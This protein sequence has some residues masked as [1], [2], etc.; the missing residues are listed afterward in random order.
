M[1][2]NNTATMKTRDRYVYGSLARI[3]DLETKPFDVRPLQR[4]NWATGDYIVGRYLGSRCS[5]EKHVVELTTGRI[6]PLLAGD[7]LVGSLAVRKA[8]FETVGDWHLI[9]ADNMM[10]DIC[11]SGM[12]GL[13]TSRS[14]MKQS[15]PA[16]LYQGH[17]VRNGRKVCMKDF[18]PRVTPT[19]PPECPTI[20][21]VGTS[22][23]TGKTNTAKV[24]IR[25]LKEIGFRRVV[26]TKLTG[27][28]YLHD[29]LVMEEGMADVV[30]DFVDAGMPST[31]MPP[32]EYR[33][34]LPTLFGILSSQSP[35]C[36]VAEIGAS[37]CEPYNGR[38]VL[39]EMSPQFVVLCASDAYAV[40]GLQQELAGLQAFHP[41][42]VCGIAADTSA[43]IDL[44]KQLSGLP[45][46]SLTDE[47]SVD[48]LR[49]MLTQALFV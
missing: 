44:V 14:F 3:S 22:M 39:E 2:L 37:P 8:T 40:I 28:G 38:V 29:I 16:F 34:V 24:V 35:D 9:G 20:L 21:I 31:V 17:V 1:T 11:G 47:K 6:R 10:H 19:G 13:E 26:A 32:E 46:L 12:F 30:C 7:K 23:S 4:D 43:G 18:V 49:S 36:I 25:L 15:S 33:Q 41:N 27:A 42:V 5:L 45:A 48:E